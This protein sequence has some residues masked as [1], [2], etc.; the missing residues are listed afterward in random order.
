LG[1]T[2]A[3]ARTNIGALFFSVAQLAFAAFPLV[4]VVFQQRPIYYKEV[5]A[6]DYDLRL[7]SLLVTSDISACDFID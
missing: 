6:G 2:Q 5:L 1:T 4:A 7:I 3:D